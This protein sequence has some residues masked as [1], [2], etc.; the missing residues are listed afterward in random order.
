[1]V[2]KTTREELEAS[3]IKLDE[4]RR[5]GQALR[6][7]GE[8]LECNPKAILDAL[9]RQSRLAAEGQRKQLGE[10]L[11]EKKAITPDALK[12]A[13][14]K[15]RLDRLQCCPVFSGMGLDE[16]TK[17]RDW[18]L[19]E[20]V[21]A[22]EEFITQ[23]VHGDCFYVLVDGRVLVY[24]RG[25]YGEEIPIAYVEPVASIGEMGFFSGGYRSTSVKALEESQLLRVDYS[26]LEKVFNGAPTVAKNFLDLVT[27]RLSQTDLRLQEAAIKGKVAESS[28]E[29]LSKFLDMSE[30]LTVKAGIEGLIERIET[31][32][33]KVMNAEHASLFLLD[34][35]TGELWSKEATG[36]ETRKIR[37]PVGRGIAGW[38]AQESET[39]NVVDACKDPRFDR[40]VDCRT[41]DRIGSILSVPMKNLLGETIGVIQAIDKKGGLFNQKDEELFVAFARQTAIAVESFTLY[42]KVRSY[43][44]KMAILLDVTTSVARTLDLDAL[45]LRIVEKITEILDVERSTLFMLDPKTDELWSK[46]AQGA[47]VVEIRFPRSE[48]LAG[49]CANTRQVINIKDAYQDPRFNPKVDLETGFHTK[50]VLCA[51]IINRE[52]DIVGITQAINKRGREFDQGDEDLLKSLSSQLAVALENSQLYEEVKRYSEKLRRTLLRIEMLEKVKSQLTKFV[53]FSV[54]KL[55]EQNPDELALEKSS[56]DVSVLFIDIEGFSRITEEHDQMLVNDMVESHFSVYLDCIRRYDGE[57]NETSGDGLMIIFKDGT[58]EKNNQNSVAAGMEIISANKRLNSELQFP[59]GR[60]VLHLGINSGKALVGSTKMKGLSGERWTYTA[61]GLVTVLAARIGALSRENRLYIGAETEKCLGESYE[62]EFIGPCELKNI[63]NPVPVYEVKG[64]SDSCTSTE[65]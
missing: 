39:A 60:V 37:I 32:I 41:D 54:A 15:Q 58:K 36:G 4:V 51:P 43:H 8:Y 59:W 31:T 13:I 42:Q 30:I 26:M 48:G 64:V 2:K 46:V 57:V 38:V 24:R 63:K 56:M 16:L 6:R 21:L 55:V 40:S 45:I 22:G 29:S 17:I 53:P 28:L 14:L 52:G 47:E 20:S 10:L 44:E 5:T 50:A 1:M 25:D 23:D 12:E 11:V 33:C 18:V 61:S 35:A 19:E 49:L 3:D 7:L 65:G 62:C 27:E 9:V 34:N